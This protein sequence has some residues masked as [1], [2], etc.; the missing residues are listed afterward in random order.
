MDRRTA[1]GALGGVA[2]LCLAGCLT[3]NGDEPPEEDEDDEGE[4]RVV[5]DEAFVRPEDAPGRWLRAAF[6]EEYPDAEL[7][8]VTPEAG[9]DLYVRQARREPPIDEDVYLGLSPTDLARVDEETS[10]PVFRTLE[11]D[12]LTRSHRVRNRFR[13]DDPEDRVL[14][15]LADYVCL[16]YDGSELDE[17][18]T[19]LDDLR[20]PAL[21]DTLLGQDARTSA[22]GR[23][24]LYWTVHEY[25]PEGAVDYWL[26][27]QANGVRLFDGSQDSYDAYLRDEGATVV[28]SA[29]RRLAASAAD[30]DHARH[31]L[32]YPDDQGYVTPR[33]M[34]IFADSTR[35]DLAYQFVD[36]LLSNAVQTDLAVGEHR[37]PAIASAYVDLPEWYD[38]T[39]PPGA[40]ALSV[41][42]LRDDHR[43]WLDDWTDAITN[44]EGTGHR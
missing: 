9:I 44:P 6:E 39:E 11:R 4:L 14:P 29:S 41:E 16:L 26:D 31:R 3:R 33:L 30:R 21:R 34:A 23:S 42:E 36:F 2:G 18:P 35:S 25:G 32:A 1:L 10:E 27:L 24:F 19:A 8:W 37:F 28:A 22:L 17:G 12:R 43:D 13:L 7:V 20:E 15:Y 5:T 38:D 40:A